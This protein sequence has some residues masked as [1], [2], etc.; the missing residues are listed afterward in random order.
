MPKV[1]SRS[2]VVTDTSARDLEGA[3]EEVPLIVYYCVCGHLALILGV[4]R[5]RFCRWVYVHLTHLLGVILLLI[6]CEGIPHLYVKD[7]HSYV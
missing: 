3:K 7:G 4:E 6:V 1:I 2:I 5:S